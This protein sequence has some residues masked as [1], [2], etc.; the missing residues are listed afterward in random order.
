MLI[1]AEE[2]TWDISDVQG[3]K[4]LL[5]ATNISPL[6]GESYVS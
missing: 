2:I 4:M 1:I 6:R 5:F 3:I